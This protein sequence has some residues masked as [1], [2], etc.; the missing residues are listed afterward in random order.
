MDRLFDDYASWCKHLPEHLN[1]PSTLDETHIYNLIQTHGDRV[2]I[3]VIGQYPIGHG[4]L[5]AEPRIQCHWEKCAIAWDIKP[6]L[7]S[8]NSSPWTS[9]VHLSMVPHGWIP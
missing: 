7:D 9:V 4:A 8:D 3:V 2:D 6:P 5:D 1:Y